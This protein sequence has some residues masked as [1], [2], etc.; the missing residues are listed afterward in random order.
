MV[1]EVSDRVRIVQWVHLRAHDP[2]MGTRVLVC[3]L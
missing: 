3:V 2:R 1:S